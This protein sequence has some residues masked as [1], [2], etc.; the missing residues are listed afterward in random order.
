[1]PGQET[2]KLAAIIA[3]EQRT[4]AASAEQLLKS[5]A[6]LPEVRKHRSCRVDP[7]PDRSSQTSYPVFEH[8]YHRPFRLR[9]GLGPARQS[10][11]VADRRYFKNA[12]ATGQ[13]SSG[14]YLV[15]K[16]TNKNVLTLAYPYND[17]RGTLA[18]IIVLGFDLD[19]YKH[20]IDSADLEGRKGVYPP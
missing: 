3:S 15:S 6:Q 4:R 20:L 12:L 1:M 2:Q 19:Y 13:L 5:L 8:L 16:F 9:L 14:E 10:V 7:A 18:G 17:E 11:N